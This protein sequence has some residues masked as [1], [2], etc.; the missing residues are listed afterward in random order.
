MEASIALQSNKKKRATQLD[1]LS[2]RVSHLNESME[3]V[4]QS[5]KSL[6]IYTSSGLI[7]SR[8]RGAYSSK[9]DTLFFMDSHCEVNEGWITPLLH[10]VTQVSQPIQSLYTL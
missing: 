7:R 8:V 5:F 1:C 10:T 4:L 9:G 3:P 6:N 2:D